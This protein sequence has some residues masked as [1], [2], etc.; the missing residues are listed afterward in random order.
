MGD[1]WVE[2]ECFNLCCLYEDFGWCWCVFGDLVIG[3]SV[4]LVVN[5]IVLGVFY[6]SYV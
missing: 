5:V 6:C 1:D 3:D 4:F 2:L